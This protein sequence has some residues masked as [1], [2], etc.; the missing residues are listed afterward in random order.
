MDRL[1]YHHLLYFRTV[2]REGTILRAD[3]IFSPGR[4]M[5]DTLRGHPSGKPVRFVVGVVEGIWTNR[6]GTLP[7][8]SGDSG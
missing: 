5:V 3:E 2:A 7:R 1:N 6:R 8:R 4:E